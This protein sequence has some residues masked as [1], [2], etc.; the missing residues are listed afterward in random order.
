MT[1]L[2]GGTGVLVNL[3]GMEILT[4]NET[5]ML[6]IA[7]LRESTLP[8]IEGIV[9][10]ITDRFSIDDATAR[11]DVEAFLTRLTDAFPSQPRIS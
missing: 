8:T 1:T 5:G 7:G 3:E 10:A 4:F 2:A 6:I 11:E 9:T